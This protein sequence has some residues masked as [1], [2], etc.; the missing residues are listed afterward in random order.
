MITQCG[1]YRASASVSRRW[2]V[3]GRAN[4]TNLLDSLD[5]AT[6]DRR[7]GWLGFFVFNENWDRREIDAFN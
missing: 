4:S 7:R 2:S 3:H 5:A 6:M 1:I